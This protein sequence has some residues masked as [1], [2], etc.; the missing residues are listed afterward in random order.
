MGDRWHAGR[1]TVAQEHLASAVV[2]DA[3]GIAS[4]HTVTATGES[5]ALALVCPEGEWHSTPARMAA[6]LMRDAGWRVHFLGASTPIDHLSMTLENLAPQAVAVSCTLPL[7][8]TG[9]PPLID[10]IH[11]LGIPAI[12]GGGA[13]D[14]QGERAAALGADGYASDATSA[15][16]ALNHWLDHPPEPPAQVADFR[17]TAERTTLASRRHT[18]VASAYNTLEDRLP[19]MATFDDRQRNHTRQDLDYIVRYADIALL[20][21][22][23]SVFTEFI[24]WLTRLLTARGLPSS[25]MP[26]TLSA[27]TEATGPELPGMLLLL[28]TARAVVSSDHLSSSR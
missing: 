1:Y 5:N 3:L 24:E 16:R 18:I 2:D 7:A 6:L 22:D 11:R 19:V 10:A 15:V 25:V 23:P 8:L 26:L 4:A 17:L 13:F 14:H 28:D 12:V 21:G 27:V 9:V 20:V